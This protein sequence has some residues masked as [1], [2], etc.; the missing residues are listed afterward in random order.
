MLAF[1]TGLCVG[2]ATALVIGGRAALRGAARRSSSSSSSISCAIQPYTPPAWVDTV[3][4]AA[5]SSRFRLGHLPTPLH[6][7]GLPR[8]SE[9]TE[10][11]IKRD[12]C[13]GCELSGNKVRKL[14]FLLA[15]AVEQGCD[16][17]ITVGGIQSNHCRATAAAARR[18][19]LEPHLILRVEDGEEQADP[20]LVG[21][22]MLD[23]MVGA[24]LHLVG[25]SDFARVGGWGLC[26]RL[27]A[28]LRAQGKRPYAF[29]SGGS[30]ALG[31]WGYVEAVREMRA[32]AE[33][34]GLRCLHRRRHL[35]DHR[36]RLLHHHD[37]SFA[38]HRRRSF[39]RVYFGCG[40]G[41]TAAGLALAHRLSGWDAA[42][43]ELVGLGV[44][45]DPEFF[46]D[47]IDRVRCA[48]ER[49]PPR[50]VD[51]SSCGG[52][53][54]ARACDPRPT[55]CGLSRP[56]SYAASA[57][58]ASR[59][60]R[61]DL[62]SICP[63]PPRP[64]P[65]PPPW[66]PFVLPQVLRLEDRVG[67]GYAQSTE[68]ELAFLTEVAQATGVV[69]DPVYSGKAALGMVED[70]KARPVAGRVLFVHTGGLLGLYAKEAQLQP[71]LASTGGVGA[72]EL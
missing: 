4:L 29:P 27:Q 6:A 59:A 15:A 23:R 20:G 14:E 50:G 69:L 55:P 9:D 43:C 31:T 5:P 16:S 24:R 42:G 57:W 51:P 47:K 70:L 12:D 19:G 33:A 60:A 26:E 10:V 30:D 46:Y 17:V 38:L 62:G 56:R 66:T 21:N 67:L 63:R 11:W 18:V 41:G 8:V 53:A 28:T 58:P 2:A 13:T 49:P 44:D 1:G 45:D 72:L 52:A 37:T 7:W 64:S 71:L 65:R 40:S 39:A 32:Q 68:E 61:S 34:A 54:P 36:R 48:P 3:Q 35:R 22:L 25:G